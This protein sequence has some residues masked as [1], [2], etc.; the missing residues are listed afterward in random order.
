MF[1]GGYEPDEC[2]QALVSIDG[3]LVS[4]TAAEYIAEYC[5]NGDGSP[6]Q[7]TGWQEVTIEVSLT[8][9]DH[10]IA[11]GGW[12]NKK[13]GSS[14]IMDVYFDDIEIVGHGKAPVE[15]IANKFRFHILLRAKTRVPLLKAL[16]RVDCREIE[17]DF[18]PV[19][20]S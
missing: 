18:D 8:G 19:E 2:G 17:I 16:H 4:D 15:K 12:N 14:E 7:D 9:G 6:D 11:V 10:T 3:V 5:G 1:A 13:T 20:F